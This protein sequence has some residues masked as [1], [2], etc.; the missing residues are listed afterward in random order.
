M[1][2]NLFSLKSASVQLAPP[3]T[4]DK[5]VLNTIPSRE[6]FDSTHKP[7]NQKDYLA[8][9]FS[10]YK[11]G[12]RSCENDGNPFVNMCQQLP[13]SFKKFLRA[14]HKLQLEYKEIFKIAMLCRE[15]FIISHPSRGC[16]RKKKN[17]DLKNIIN[18]SN[19]QN[20]LSEASISTNKSKKERILKLEFSLEVQVEKVKLP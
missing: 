10:T 5:L 6:T 4:Q 8:R 17:A 15:L 12:I 18:D 13:N 11:L 7:T 19:S 20:D 2:T 3:T 16:K 14:G 9:M 1:S